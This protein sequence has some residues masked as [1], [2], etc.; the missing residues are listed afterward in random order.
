MGKRGNGEG[1][2]SRRSNGG[3]M[4]QYAV[5]TPEGRK[6]KTIYG[7]TRKDVAAKLAR[8]VSDR[9]DGLVFDA[10]NLKVGEYLERWLNDSVEGNVRSRTL[11]NYQ[12]QVRRHIVPALGRIQLKTLSPAHVQGLYRSKLDAGLAPSSV[13]YIHAVLHRA[14]KQALRWGLVP[15]NVTEAVDLPKLVSEEVDAL[16]P[17]DARAFLDA[18]RGDRFE[19][20]YVVAVTTGM[21]R[22]E[23][24]GLRW[25]DIELDGAARLRVGRQLQR[26]RDGSG[27]QF[28]TPKGG[29]GRTIRLPVRTVEALKTH[30]ARQAEEKLKAGSLYEDGGLVFATEVGTPLEPSNIDRRSFKPLLEKAGLPD[31]RFHD[32]R[33]TCATALLSEGVNAKFVQELLGHADIKLTLGTYSHFLPSMGDQTATA[34]E[35]ALG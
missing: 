8:A 24:L 26:M 5:Y 18:A 7:K 22:G 10:G 14:L 23:L 25:T 17:E 6:R 31:M 9:E 20:L 3:W 28:V 35:N 21:R 2:I 15:R 12:L 27:L 19:A 33:H 13:R 1:S 11:S 30:R 32:L 34:M 4:A 16:T 29:K